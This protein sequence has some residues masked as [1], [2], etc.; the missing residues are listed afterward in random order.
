MRIPHFVKENFIIPH[1][2]PNMCADRGRLSTLSTFSRGKLVDKF[3]LTFIE[4]L[5]IISMLATLL[6]IVCPEQQPYPDRKCTGAAGTGD[7]PN[8]QGNMRLPAAR[9]TRHSRAA[10]INRIDRE[11]A[12]S[13]VEVTSAWARVT[14]YTGSVTAGQ[15]PALSLLRRKSTW[16]K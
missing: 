7:F 11:P 15:F 4:V 2:V 12:A 13:S 9:R 6:G 8:Q 14:L 10:A 1:L 5:Y 16:Q 3:F